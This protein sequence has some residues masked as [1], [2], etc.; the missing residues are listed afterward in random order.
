[1][2]SISLTKN[3]LEGSFLSQANKAYFLEGGK[4]VQLP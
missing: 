2:L 1:M 3:R 4:S